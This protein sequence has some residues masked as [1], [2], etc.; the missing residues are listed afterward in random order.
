MGGFTRRRGRSR[1]TAAAMATPVATAGAR[2]PAPKPQRSCSW[3]T[4]CGRTRSTRRTRR[5]SGG[6]RTGDAPDT[7]SAVRVGPHEDLALSREGTL[8]TNN[9]SIIPTVT[10]GNA[11][12]IGSGAH[13]SAAASSATRCSCRRS[14]RSARSAP[15]TPGAAAQARSGHGR[16]DRPH[17]DARR[18][19]AGRGQDA[20]RAGLGH[21]RRHAAAEPARR[22]APARWSTPA[23]RARRSRSRRSSARTSSPASAPRRATRAPNN[24]LVTYAE[25]VLRDGLLTPSSPDVVLNWITEPDGSQHSFGV[26]SPQALSGI[27]NSDKELG[28][29]IDKARALGQHE[30]DR[31]LRPRLLLRDYNVNVTRGAR[32]GRAA[33]ARHRR[34]DRLDTGPGAHPRRSTATRSGSPRS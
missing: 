22:T 6:A 5:T 23:T 8:F 20:A 30:R 12:G 7:F 26:G 28:L 11:T 25:T 3:S 27:K 29:V 9:H 13:P 1:T 34:H 19:P 18:A 17:R 15:V 33:H 2:T 24:K 21:V 10:R 32:A 31:R 16:Q 14:A 4:A